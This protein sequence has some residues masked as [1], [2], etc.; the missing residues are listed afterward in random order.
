MKRIMSILLTITMLL[1]ITASVDFSAFAAN[2]GNLGKNVTWSISGDTLTISGTG[3]AEFDYGK[4]PWQS[5]SDSIKH[6]VVKNGITAL[7]EHFFEDNEKIEDISLP[8]SLE[9]ICSQAMLHCGSLKSIHIPKNV[10]LIG[11]FSYS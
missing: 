9:A 5:K 2:S 11:C 7:G 6:A 1:G 3:V 4:Q 8:D 10:R